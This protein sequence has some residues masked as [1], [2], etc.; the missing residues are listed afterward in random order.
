MKSKHLAIAVL[1]ALVVSL[2]SAGGFIINP[3]EEPEE[4]DMVFNSMPADKVVQ[5]K[6]A[7]HKMARL[8]V[9]H[10][11]AGDPVVTGV[12]F[13]EMRDVKDEPMAVHAALRKSI[14]FCKP[15]TGLTTA[16]TTIGKGNEII[17]DIQVM[18]RPFKL[19]P[20]T[21]SEVEINFMCE[22]LKTKPCTKRN[23]T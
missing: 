13:S 20:K 9:G 5:G 14:Y 11:D 21:L 17:Q 2:V 8:G 19:E 7:V 1:T 12:I 15:K 6:E 23:C 18:I 4:E 3:H 10:T 16:L 22:G